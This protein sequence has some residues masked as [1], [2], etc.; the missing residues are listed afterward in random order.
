MYPFSA[1]DLS[2]LASSPGALPSLLQPPGPL[3]SSQLG[4]QLLPGGGAPPALSEA[5]SPL[6]CLLQS[7][8]VRGWVSVRKK[9]FP[10]PGKVF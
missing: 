8:Q 3:L 1:G 2:S 7:L 9:V 10:K 5:S 6:A 4:L